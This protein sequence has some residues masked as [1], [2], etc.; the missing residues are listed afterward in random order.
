MEGT[1]AKAAQKAAAPAPA[2]KASQSINAMMNA[3]LDR[4]GFRKRFN[5]LLGKRAPQFV[6]S[7]VSM[8]NADE[9]TPAGI[10]SV[11][12]FCDPSSIKSCYFRSPY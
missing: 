9:K 3:M 8:V 2:Q 5:D 6:S 10:L 11:A 1:I 7:I 4:D 12:S